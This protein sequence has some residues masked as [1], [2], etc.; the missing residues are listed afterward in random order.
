M[1]SLRAFKSDKL[2]SLDIHLNSPTVELHSFTEDELRNDLVRPVD[3]VW[4]DVVAQ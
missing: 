3:F 1:N 4:L 2:S